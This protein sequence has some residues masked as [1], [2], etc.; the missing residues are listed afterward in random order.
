MKYIRNYLKVKRDISINKYNIY[1]STELD[2][3]NSLN[4][5]SKLRLANNCVRFSN[6]IISDIF[7]TWQL[8]S[9]ARFISLNNMWHI[10][11]QKIKRILSPYSMY[12][13][14]SKIQD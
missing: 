14:K 3:W 10:I 13:I 2:Y 1:S 11:D 8:E 6:A 7:Y 5:F 9:V 4:I 12:R